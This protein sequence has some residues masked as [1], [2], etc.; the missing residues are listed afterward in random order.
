[1]ARMTLGELVD[2]ILSSMDSDPVT[3]YDDTVESRQVADILRTTYYNL[4][5]GRDWP[6]LYSMFT[7]TETSAST[8]CTMTI[9]T[10]TIDL[11]WVKYNVRSSTDTKD[12]YQEIIFKE[13]REFMALL[14]ARDSSAS[15]IDQKTISS[16]KY[17]FYNDRAPTYYTSINETTAIFDA[18]DVDVETYLKTT[19]TQVYGKSYPTV[20]LSDGMY[21]DLPPDAF[22]LLLEEA[23]SRA[24]VEL[25]QINNPKADQWAGIQKR[26]MSQEAWKIRNGVTYSSY[27][28]NGKK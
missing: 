2:D 10:A 7:L 14:D 12:R 8:P 26:R 21:F 19:K 24:F 11:K 16:I 4:I 28:R 13:P 6:N 20:T 23:K 17:N 15:N 27:G 25:K 9:P 18:Y 5:D 22:S 3:T 1:M